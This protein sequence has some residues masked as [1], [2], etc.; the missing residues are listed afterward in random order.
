MTG[1]RAPV[2]PSGDRSPGV[3][4]GRRG[5]V[6]PLSFVIPARNEERF[7]AGTI[8]SIRA[9]ASRW[10]H[11]VILVDNGSEDATRAIARSAG[12]TVCED[13]AK[14]IA[15][16]RNTGA[17]RA[18]GEVLVFL[19]ADV[20]ITAAWGAAIGTVIDQIRREKLLITGARCRVAENPGW[21]ERHWFGP[22]ATESGQYINSGHLVVG[23]E[24]FEDMS[25]FDESLV[26]GEDWEF[27]R[28]GRRRGAR[29]ANNPVLETIHEGYPKTL[30]QFIRREKW[31]GLQD[32]RTLESFLQS[33]PAQ[34]GA[35]YW[36]IGMGGIV[37]AIAAHS[38]FYLAVALVLDALL[39][40]AATMVRRRRMKFSLAHG[41]LLQHAYFF[42]R[43]L[44]L[45]ELLRGNLS[46]K[47]R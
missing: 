39:C 16:L 28:R 21:I 34:F 29:V 25:G 27:C 10:T 3:D 31:H 17:R 23:R 38:A 32:F 13:A 5:D 41:M 40:L 7:L 22:M 18:S 4:S 46:R 12:C 30:A 33:R 44:S 8:S 20:R 45:V 14:T 37:L 9:H 47:A 11:E 35:A 42:G 19:D 36:M 6:K 26:T 2:A 24:L 43:G 1:G 15:A